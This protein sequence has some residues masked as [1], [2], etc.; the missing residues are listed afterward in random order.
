M[1][2]DEQSD[3]KSTD[4][5]TDESTDETTDKSTDETTDESTDQ[6]E[7]ESGDDE[8]GDDESGDDGAIE[9]KGGAGDVE[10]SDKAED[11]TFG[12]KDDEPANEVQMQY[13]QPLAEETGEDVPDDMSEA[14]AA[15]KINEM[16]DNA[17]GT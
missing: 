8:S 7:D 17:A 4:E 6:S 5:T 16:Q 13:L 1:A 9:N 15:D 10:K 11:P 12:K 14:D 3:D 2:D